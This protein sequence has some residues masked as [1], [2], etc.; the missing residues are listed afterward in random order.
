MSTPTHKKRNNKTLKASSVSTKITK[1]DTAVLRFLKKKKPSEAKLVDF[2]QD[3]WLK[4][5]KS[6]LSASTAKKIAKRLMQVHAITHYK[7]VNSTR[8]Q[9]GGYALTG[10]PLSGFTGPGNP[11]LPVLFSRPADITNASF[12]PMP[13]WSI[14]QDRGCGS[15]FAG[16]GPGPTMGSNRVSRARSRRQRGGAAFSIPAS[17]PMNFEMLGANTLIGVR[18]PVMSVGNPVIPGFTST[19]VPLRG[20]DTP[21]AE[22]ITKQLPLVWPA[23]TSQ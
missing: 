21:Q 7:P 8:K 16:V 11:A 18:N 4:Q 1:F 10:A 2:V 6:Y 13:Y 15:D 19:Y 3:E 22:V 14:A 17:Q 20:F 9:R 5:T 23:P 12:N